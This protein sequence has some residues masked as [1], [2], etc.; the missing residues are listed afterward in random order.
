[1]SGSHRLLLVRHIPVLDTSN[2]PLLA[3]LLCA[4]LVTP[5]QGQGQLEMVLNGQWGSKRLMVPVSRA[6]M[7]ELS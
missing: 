4:D 3:Y 1:M 6:G 2:I 5:S 7:E